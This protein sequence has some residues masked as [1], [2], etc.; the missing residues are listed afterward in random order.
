MNLLAKLTSMQSRRPDARSRRDRCISAD[1]D[2]RWEGATS[3]CHRAARA[4]VSAFDIITFVV[5]RVFVAPSLS[6]KS[7][8]RQLLR[9]RH[10]PLERERRSLAMQLIGS[11]LILTSC[12]HCAAATG[13]ALAVDP[14]NGL[15]APL[16]SLTLPCKT[17]GYAIGFRQAT[18][19]L[20]LNQTFDEPSILV[21]DV[22]FLNITGTRRFTKI[23]CSRRADGAFGP[24]FTIAN[25]SVAFSG[26]KTQ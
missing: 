19:V 17:I 26:I 5:F 7:L 15:D 16:C 24:A 18:N 20:L 8:S 10:Q 6:A 23:D 9:T 13:V 14:S 1:R 2:W 4:H 3:A 11:I 25:S 12:S 22:A 21:A